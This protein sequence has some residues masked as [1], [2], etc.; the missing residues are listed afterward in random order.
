VGEEGLASYRAAPRTFADELGLRVDRILE[1]TTQVTNAEATG[2]MS[3]CGFTCGVRGATVRSRDSIC[4]HIPTSHYSNAFLLRLSDLLNREV[5]HEGRWW[6]SLSPTYCDV[7]DSPAACV[8][9]PF[10]RGSAVKG[11]TLSRPQCHSPM[12][13]SGRLRWSYI[14]ISTLTML[15]VLSSLPTCVRDWWTGAGGCSAAHVTGAAGTSIR[16]IQD[17]FGGRVWSF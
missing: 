9:P 3:R 12:R 14:T 11:V 6:Y 8:A 7:R 16:P 13:R 17:A 2:G 5:M 1:P 10:Q 15:S 4:R